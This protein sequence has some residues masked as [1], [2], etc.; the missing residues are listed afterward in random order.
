[1]RIA[2]SSEWNGEKEGACFSQALADSN[3]LHALPKHAEFFLRHAFAKREGQGRQ[4]SHRV[5]HDRSNFG[6]GCG[7]AVEFVESCFERLSL[8]AQRLQS[9]VD[10]VSVFRRDAVVSNYSADIRFSLIG[11]IGRMEFVMLDKTR[12][13]KNRWTSTPDAEKLPLASR[14]DR[15]TNVLSTRY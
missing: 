12:W 13:R 15:W 4:E 9:R 8:L 3:P 10:D 11:K 2:A 5:G 1:M 14:K 7:Q 6:L